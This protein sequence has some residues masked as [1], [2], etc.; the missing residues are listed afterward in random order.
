MNGILHQAKQGNSTEKDMLAAI[1]K[2]LDDLLGIV[3]PSK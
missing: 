2:Y 1:I 3:T